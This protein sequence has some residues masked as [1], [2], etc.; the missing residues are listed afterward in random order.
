ML[1]TSLEEIRATAVAWAADEA[2][3]RFPNDEASI[4]QA[5]GWVSD[6]ELKDMTSDDAHGAIIHGIR[7]TPKACPCP[8]AQ[9]DPEAYCVH[10]LALGIQ[11][12]SLQQFTKLAGEMTPGVPAI[13]PPFPGSPGGPKA[14]PAPPAARRTD[15]PSNAQNPLVIEALATSQA[16]C[17]AATAATPVQYRSF[18]L[19]LERDKK[20]AGTSLYAKIKNPY[21][22][23]DGRVKWAW[24][25]H[26]A[27]GAT[28][29]MDTTFSSE[30][31]T[32]S[33]E[34]STEYLMCHVVVHS[35]LLGHADGWSKVCIGGKGVDA[36]NP[37]ENAQTSAV[38]RAL[39]FLGYGLY[40]SGIASADDIQ[41]LSKDAEDAA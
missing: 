6:G 3:K 7:V 34:P 26:R 5:A 15:L 18:L 37:M 11:R 38:G 25:E 17:D 40:G 31:S 9:A 24:D 41:A 8:V 10:R 29:Q 4:R 13:A 33:S 14:A 28:I 27:A 30:P 19:F 22:T 20:I 1:V 36:S 32:F 23:V 35:S 39:G 12:R 16:I 21:L 2:R